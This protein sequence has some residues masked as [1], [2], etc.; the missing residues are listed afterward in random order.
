ML[1]FLLFPLIGDVRQKQ[2]DSDQLQNDF[3]AFETGIRRIERAVAQIDSVSTTD[4]GLVEAA[5]PASP[6][7]PNLLVVI[8]SLIID[9]G[10]ITENISIQENVA[11]REQAA[12]ISGRLV[13]A[14]LRTQ[15]LADQGIGVAEVSFTA[16]GTYESFKAFSEAAEKSLR[17]FDL[18]TIDFSA[19]Q[20]SGGSTQFRFDVTMRTYYIFAQ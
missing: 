5:L 3:F 9:A 1:V 18:A 11:V 7:V 8:N 15:E 6:D 19:V 10:L 20:Q 2:A 13:E 12:Q 16:R 14:G 17:L 4:K